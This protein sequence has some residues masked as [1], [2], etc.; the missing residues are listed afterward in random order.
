MSDMA[1]NMSGVKTV[2][3]AKSVYLA[4]LALELAQNVLSE[5]GDFLVKIFQGEGFDNYLKNLRLHFNKVV[6][7][8][9]K[10]SRPRSREVYLLARG[11]K[12]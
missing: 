10:A 1:P 4:E 8:K 12:G 3:Q 9:P 2:D 7:R 5:N 11:F 6:S